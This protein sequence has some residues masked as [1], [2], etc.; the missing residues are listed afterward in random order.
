[1]GEI[2]RLLRHIFLSRSFERD[3]AGATRQKSASARRS[4]DL[5]APL[6]R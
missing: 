4:V 5:P 2:M 3:E 6:G 1:M